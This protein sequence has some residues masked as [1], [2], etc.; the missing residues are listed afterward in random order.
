MEKN[1]L[2]KFIER[3]DAFDTRKLLEGV[4]LSTPGRKKRHRKKSRRRL[5]LRRQ[6]GRPRL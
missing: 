6:R 4:D 5:S 1:D 3:S 2:D